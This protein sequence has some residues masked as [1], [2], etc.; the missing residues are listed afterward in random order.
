MIP[1][2]R[3]ADTPKGSACKNNREV[4]SHEEKLIAGSQ[5]GVWTHKFNPQEIEVKIV[6]LDEL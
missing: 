5:S 3:V 2:L 1:K 6:K 4:I